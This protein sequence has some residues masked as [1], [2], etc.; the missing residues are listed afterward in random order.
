[1]TLEDA[2]EIE[3]KCVGDPFTAIAAQIVVGVRDFVK[4][5]RKNKP[6]EDWDIDDVLAYLKSPA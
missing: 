3:E 6:F 4:D 1:M 5:S 2:A